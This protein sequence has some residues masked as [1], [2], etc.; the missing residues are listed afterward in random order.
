MAKRLMIFLILVVAVAPLTLG[1][2]MTEKLDTAAMSV[3]KNEGMNNSQVMEILSYLT[4]VYGPRLTWSPEY[5]EAAEWT[6]GKLRDWGLQ[7]VAYDE[8]E[9]IG[10]GWTL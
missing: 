5:R 9:P 4:D 3:I 10:R 2:M 7:N 1:Q 6:S 8:W